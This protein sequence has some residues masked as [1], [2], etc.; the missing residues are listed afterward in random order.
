MKRDTLSILLGLNLGCLAYAVFSNTLHLPYAN[1]VA[2]LGIVCN[3]S[4]VVLAVMEVY[5]NP[6]YTS[7]QKTMWILALLFLGMLAGIVYLMRTR[8][9]R[10]DRER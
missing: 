10:F 1:V 2:V 9:N 4:F 3:I 7:N 5:R 6:E 8:D